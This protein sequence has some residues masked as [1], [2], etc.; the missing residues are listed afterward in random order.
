MENRTR[1]YR[2]MAFGFDNMTSNDCLM[3][4]Q[5]LAGIFLLALS[6]VNGIWIYLLIP[7]LQRGY[8]DFVSFYCGGLMVRRGLGPRLYDLP[9]QYRTQ[10]E[11]AP[12][13]DIRNA[14]LPYNHPPFEALLFVP[15]TYLGFFPAYLLWVVLNIAMLISCLFVLRKTYPEIAGLK[16]WFL[17]VAMGAFIPVATA[18][19]HGQDSLLL[20]LLVTL[21][22]SYLDGDSEVA[23][24]VALAACLFKFQIAVPMMLILSPRRPR[25]LL[26]FLPAA[27]TLAAISALVVGVTGAT[28]YL[29]FVFFLEKSGAG[30][31]IPAAGSPNL[32]GFIATLAGSSERSSYT[33]WITVA[34]SIVAAGFAEWMI[35]NVDSMRL[36]YAIAT[37][38]AA[39][40]SYHVLAHDL[41]IMVPF[42]LLLFATSAPPLRFEIRGD[43]VLLVSLYSILWLAVRWPVLNPLWCVPAALWIYW[44]LA[45][46]PAAV[47]TLRRTNRRESPVQRMKCKTN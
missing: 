36:I 10:L 9:L 27:A 2:I 28:N 3:R 19:M 33:M 17:V 18:L 38:T 12:H 5:R 44:K 29:K 20:M 13:V 14:A 6:L 8:Q 22:L 46:V 39:M 4:K 34:A 30:G 26:G 45:Y 15:L 11:Y 40:V 47:G 32:H 43:T 24:G 7:K 31:A 1:N 41:T 21:A 37:L 23:A 16:W 42:V 25:L 35:T